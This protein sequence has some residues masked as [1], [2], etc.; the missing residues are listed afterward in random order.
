MDFQWI[1]IQIVERISKVLIVTSNVCFLNLLLRNFLHKPSN[2]NGILI[3]H[4]LPILGA[5]GKLLYHLK[6]VIGSLSLTF[7]TSKLFSIRDHF[8]IGS[9]LVAIPEPDVTSCPP[10]RLRRWQLINLFH[11]IIYIYMAICYSY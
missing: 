11:T 3:L 7:E 4:R 5:C 10:N 9:P 1:Y 6:R 8:L 2:F